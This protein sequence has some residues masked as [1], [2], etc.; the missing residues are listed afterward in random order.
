MWSSCDIK[1]TLNHCSCL[2]HS[3]ELFPE[4]KQSIQYKT[5]GVSNLASQGTFSI[6]SIHCFFSFGLPT[7]RKKWFPLQKLIRNPN[8]SFSSPNKH[9]EREKLRGEQYN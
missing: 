7:L 3:F 4:S 8:I 1:L 2:L 6:F 9:R 5:A